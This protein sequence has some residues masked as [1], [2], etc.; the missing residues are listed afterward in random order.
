MSRIVWYGSLIS[1]CLAYLVIM[2]VYWLHLPREGPG[3]VTCNSLWDG[4]NWNTINQLYQKNQR[5][6]Q[7]LDSDNDGVPCE[8]QLIQETVG[9]Q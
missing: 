3:V 8:K 7:H 9:E 2:V 5:A 1:I 6:Y 4:N